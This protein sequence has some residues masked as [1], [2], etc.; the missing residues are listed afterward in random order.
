MKRRLTAVLA[1]M[2]AACGLLARRSRT[3]SSERSLESR[4]EFILSADRL[5]PFFAFSHE[6]ADQLTDA[7]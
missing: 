5:V 3:R 6:S 2:G 4:G 1:T 7:G